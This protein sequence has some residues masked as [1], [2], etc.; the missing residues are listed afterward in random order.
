MCIKSGHG[1]D[2]VVRKQSVQHDRYTSA[3]NGGGG[4][5]GGSRLSETVM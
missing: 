2:T 5:G 3:A 4:G 1:F